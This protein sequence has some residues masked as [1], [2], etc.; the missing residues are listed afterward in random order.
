MKGLFLL[1][2]ALVLVA[3]AALAEAPP[4]PADSFE[5]FWAEFSSALLLGDR[6]IVE[7]STF[8][9][10]MTPDL[11]MIEPGTD[12][13]DAVWEVL[14]DEDFLLALLT[15]D[16]PTVM[17]EGDEDRTVVVTMYYDADGDFVDIPE[18]HEGD[19]TESALMLS[20]EQLGAEWLFTGLMIAG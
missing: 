4:V 11:E 15:N 3:P 2:A 7:L 13:F 10:F 18:L 12:A 5:D 9:D 19:L 8:S 1:V 20:F 14:T 17:G 16:A 6:D